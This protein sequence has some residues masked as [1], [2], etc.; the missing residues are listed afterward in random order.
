MSA[1]LALFIF[2]FLITKTEKSNL[3]VEIFFD[4]IEQ[5]LFSI[6]QNSR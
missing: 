2:Y 1:L 5:F 4:D 3:T 6:S